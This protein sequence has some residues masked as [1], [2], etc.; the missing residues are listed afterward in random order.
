MTYEEVQK[1]LSETPKTKEGLASFKSEMLAHIA[2]DFYQ[3]HGFPY[4]MFVEMLEEKNLTGIEQLNFIMNY[5][6]K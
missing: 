4:E 2:F 5:Y 6:K 3:K 1:K